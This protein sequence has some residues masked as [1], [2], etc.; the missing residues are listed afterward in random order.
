MPV[1]MLR[2]GAK[3]LALGLGGW[4]LLGLPARAVSLEDIRQLENLINA[5]G[6]ETVVSAPVRPTTPGTTKTTAKDSTVW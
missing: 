2:A 4:L 6:S 5:S 3:L 1:S